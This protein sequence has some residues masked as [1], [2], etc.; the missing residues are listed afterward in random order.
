MRT[1]KEIFEEELSGEP[2]TQESVIEAI[3]IAREEIITAIMDSI[4]AGNNSNITIFH[5]LIDNNLFK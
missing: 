1:S 4:K 2:L 5:I 3:Q